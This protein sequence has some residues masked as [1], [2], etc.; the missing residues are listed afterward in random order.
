MKIINLLTTKKRM[1]ILESGLL[2][3]IAGLGLFSCDSPRKKTKF[4]STWENMKDRTWIGSAYWANPLQDWRI[5]DGRLECINQGMNRNVHLLTYQLDQEST[6]TMSVTV[7]HPVTGFS[8]YVGLRFASRGNLDEYRHNTINSVTFYDAKLKSDGTLILG[9]SSVQILWDDTVILRLNLTPHGQ[10]H[11]AQLIAIDPVGNILGQVASE[12][13]SSDIHGNLALVC[14]S[15]RNKPGTYGKPV[16]SFEDW[17][18]KGKNLRGG[19]GQRW[20]PILWSQYT[21]DRGILKLSTQF[22]P[23]GLDDSRKAYLE[24]D[25][26]DGWKATAE[27]IID[28]MARV[29]LF[30]VENWDESFNVPYRVVFKLDGEKHT[31]KGVIR[32]NPVDQEEVSVAAFTGNKDYGF[33]NIPIVNN[34]I[35]LDPDL[36]FFSGD[37]IYE[38]VAGYSFVRKP[39][40]VATLDYLR[41]WYIFGWSFGDILKTRPSVI[42]PDDHDVYQGNL[43]G[44]SGRAIPSGQ[45]FYYGG[46]V[47]D[48]AWVNMVQRTQTAHLPDPFDPT[49]VEQNITVYYTALDWGGVSFAILEDRNFKSGT[50]DVDIDNPGDA[51]LLGDR[52]LRFLDHWVRDWQN[53]SMKAILSQTVFA[54]CHTNAVGNVQRVDTDCNGWPPKGR[55]KAL[56]IIRKGYAFMI[57]GDNHLPTVVHH[58]IDSWEDAGVSFTVPSVA[59]GFPRSWEPGNAGKPKYPGGPAY[60]MEKLQ[61]DTDHL[62]RFKTHWNHF[63]TM[64]AVANP[65]VILPGG[66]TRKGDYELLQQ[67]RSGFGL[68]RF[69]KTGRKI[70]IECYPVLATINETEREQYDGWPVVIDQKI[71]YD[72]KPL[73]YLR[74]ISIEGNPDPVLRVYEEQTGKLVYA[75]RL[76]T[77]TVRPWVFEEGRYKVELGYPESGEWKTFNGMKIIYRNKN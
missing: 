16:I 15:N 26:G 12:Y 65:E 7:S 56:R 53:S 40:D 74:E 23:I 27:A 69:N 5:H 6:L 62:G 32:H 18:I 14:H 50:I 66:K 21:V 73:G 57:A 9:D 20:G 48:A 11:M 24:L 61:R 30:R 42:I 64:L 37:Q 46:Y 31:Y 67:K 38:D 52:Q 45:P 36:L 70:T 71:N 25:K 8:G 35:K 4:E 76:Q 54:Q 60:A 41:K 43:W 68:V 39:V 58:G 2:F 75:I 19:D 72:R 63:I 44:Q 51:P 28:D 29:A 13:E 59:A 55:N 1:I 34:V 33:P 49:P 10:K 17:K 3:L 22:V 47:M 77:N